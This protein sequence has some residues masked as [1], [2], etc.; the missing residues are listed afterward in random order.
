MPGNHVFPTL[1]YKLYIITEEMK[2]NFKKSANLVHLFNP[3]GL[4]MST[5][6]KVG[7]Q[8]AAEKG[9]MESLWT[10]ARP[11]AFVTHGQ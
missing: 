9:E 5:I 1:G 2:Q 11:T 4:P 7:L 3:A 6:E 10:V 8:W